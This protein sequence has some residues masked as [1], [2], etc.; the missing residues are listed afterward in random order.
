MS[1]SSWATVVTPPT[2]G[3]E[4][5]YLAGFDRVVKLVPSGANEVG[6]IWS[7]ASAP[8]ATSMAASLATAI[9]PVP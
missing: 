1:W 8:C 7:E 5:C 9:V 4:R 3:V 6:L 2:A